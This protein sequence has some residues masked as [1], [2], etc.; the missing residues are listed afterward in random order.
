M[1]LISKELAKFLEKWPFSELT[2]NLDHLQ[3]LN[4]HG[5]RGLTVVPQVCTI[6]KPG[7]LEPAN[8][9]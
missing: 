2:V 4:L 5:L 7:P 8:E 9:T 3:R 1:N 6:E